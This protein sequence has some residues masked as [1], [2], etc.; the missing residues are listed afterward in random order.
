MEHLYLQPVV[1]NSK[2]MD[3]PGPVLS[4]TTDHGLRTTDQTHVWT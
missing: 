4:L 1:L 2:P 3:N